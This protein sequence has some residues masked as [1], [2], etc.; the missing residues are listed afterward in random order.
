METPKRTGVPRPGWVHSRAA[1]SRRADCNSRPSG[2]VASSGPT[3]AK[4]SRA[5]AS[6]SL[7]P[8]ILFSP[9][10]VIDEPRLPCSEG[11]RQGIFCVPMTTLGK[12]EQLIVESG[13]VSASTVRSRASASTPP[14]RARSASG[15][16]A[17][18]MG[19]WIGGA[20]PR[21]TTA[22]I[23]SVSVHHVPP[24]RERAPGNGLWRAA[25]ERSDAFTAEGPD[26]ATLPK[27][28]P[29]APRGRPC[30]RESGARAA[31]CAAD[32]RGSRT[33]SRAK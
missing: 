8:F 1:S 7:D 22:S 11:A 17:D 25:S 20:R 2:G 29:G 6:R 24:A 33:L 18:T 3:M 9:P 15:S 16:S 10:V 5:R 26:P 21:A 23:G 28:P 13:L 19:G 4:R 14:T 31:S 32:S 30:A 12:C 27:T